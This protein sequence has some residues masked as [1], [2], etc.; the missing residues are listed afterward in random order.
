[1]KV[2]IFQNHKYSRLFIVKQIPQYTFNVHS[3]STQSNVGDSHGVFVVVI[4][5]VSNIIIYCIHL[6]LFSTE[7]EKNHYNNLNELSIIYHA[8]CSIATILH[9][10]LWGLFI[11]L[12]IIV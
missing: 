2:D 4:N 5:Y 9:Y 7:E 12:I 10:Y 6:L 3:I 11:I 8:N 1:M